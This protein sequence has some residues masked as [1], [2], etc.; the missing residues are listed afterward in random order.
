MSKYGAMRYE[1]KKRRIAKNYNNGGCAVNQQ[2]IKCTKHAIDRFRERMLKN[3][4]PDEDVEKRI[5]QMVR[6]SRLIGLSDGME[7]RSYNGRIFVC[8]RKMHDSIETIT[9][10]TILM[11]ETLQKDKAGGRIDEF[12]SK[13]EIKASKR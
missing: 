11:G 7:H 2:N 12:R 9:V 6:Q 4:M 10:V 8:D 13:A 3:G 1:D 5:V